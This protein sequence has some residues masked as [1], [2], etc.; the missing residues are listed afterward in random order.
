[1]KI[2]PQ[3]VKVIIGA[4]W[5]TRQ[6]ADRAKATIKDKTG[7]GRDHKC[8]HRVGVKTAAPQTDGSKDSRQEKQPDIAADRCTRVDP[9]LSGKCLNAKKIDQG[10]QKSDDDDEKTGQVLSYDQAGAGERERLQDIT[11][12]R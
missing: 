2:D 4:C 11:G 3:H 1:M 10:R 9:S 5:Q 12:T 8:D 7:K 6:P